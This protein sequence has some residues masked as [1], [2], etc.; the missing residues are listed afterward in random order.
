MSRPRPSDVPEAAR[1]FLALADPTR[2]ELLRHLGRGGRTVG[3]L[4]TATGCPQPKVSRHL[5]V[6]KDSGLV[7][8]VREG[9]NVRYELTTRGSWPAE[10][11]KWMDRLDSG[12]LQA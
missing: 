4:V 8:D 3:D 11:R 6:L 5:K 12:L 10:A 9:R 7:R 1:F 2:L